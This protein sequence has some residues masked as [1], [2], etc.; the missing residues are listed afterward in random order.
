MAMV[1]D[2]NLS[3]E[4]PLAALDGCTYVL[5]TA[6]VAPNGKDPVLSDSGIVEALRNQSNKSLRWVGYLSTTGV[7][8]NHEG[9]EVDETAPLMPSSKRG[10]LRAQAEADWAN[11]GLPVY[12]FRLPG[13][14]GPNR[15]PLEK[16]RSGTARRIRKENHVFC[17][18]HV[19]DICNAL[20]TSM[21]VAIASSES[22]LTRSYPEI[23]NLVDD[24]PESAATVTEYAAALLVVEP[25]PVEEFETAVM[26]E[27]ARSF[28]EDSKR[29]SNSKLKKDINYTFIYP[30]YKEGLVSQLEE[31]SQLTVAQYQQRQRIKNM[32]YPTL[33]KFSD[34]WSS[35]WSAIV[36]FVSLLL[37]KVG[38]RKRV[39]RKPAV[40]L[41]D[42]GSIRAAST[43][44]LRSIA[45]SLSKVLG[46]HVDPVS[47]RWSD[48]VKGSELGGIEA[49]TF[50]AA[51]KARLENGVAD[52]FIILP[53]FFGPSET[54]PAAVEEVIKSNKSRY[55]EV[56]FRVA[57]SLVDCECS[58]DDNR[59]AQILALRVKETMAKENL[60][61]ASVIM[62]DHGSPS[63]SVN[64]VRN[65]VGQ[66]LRSLLMSEGSG[67]VTA[68]VASSMESRGGE[69]YEFNKPLLEN[70][71][72]M[73]GFNSG[74]VIVSLMFISPGKHA[75]A[76]GDIESI[77]GN[78][79]ANNPTLLP[80]ITDIIGSHDIMVDILRSRYYGIVGE[81]C[82][83]REETK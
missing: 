68:F 83:A 53:L 33:R 67:K 12:I 31:E 34:G 11:T 52:D 82:D 76:G 61:S 32:V 79:K 50:A 22:N 5:T 59:I 24:L 37:I 14:Y 44:N 60:E 70:S 3:M 49:E 39:P 2:S 17:R 72:V 1:W 66:Q 81:K 62:V 63:V 26:S 6:Q 40:F 74:P 35:L 65:H 21:K 58:P 4:E 16:V 64:N 19:D 47:V 8:G 10:K 36:I 78:A 45:S 46:V 77:V 69:A 30:T 7:Y 25:P 18:V 38:L 56:R 41:M 43:L 15:G 29:V 28:Y 13:I 9:K 57:K 27:M 48:R 55:P 51:V 73:E 75:G 80:Y 23:Y 71:L 20:M 42:N 54:V